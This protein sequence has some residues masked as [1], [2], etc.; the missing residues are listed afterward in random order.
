MSTIDAASETASGPPNFWPKQFLFCLFLTS[1]GPR[2][3]GA[4]S[5]VKTVMI[6]RFLFLLV[7][8]I[9]GG[10]ALA[11]DP[12]G[13]IRPDSAVQNAQLPEVPIGEGET[14]GVEPGAPATGAPAGQDSSVLT[15]RIERLER[16]LRQMTGE[17]E[18]LQH[19]VQVLEE[20]LRAAR[21]QEPVK[22]AEPAKTETPRPV[23]AAKPANPATVTPSAST[24]DPGQTTRDGKRADAFKPSSAPDAP[25]A[26]KPLGAATPSAP[27]ETTP[28]AAAS[29]A[30]PRES[31]APMDIAHG[32]LVGAQPATGATDTPLGAALTPSTA[33]SGGA[34]QE[35]DD[36]VA[37]LK[38]GRYEAAEQMLTT[39]LS[40]NPKSKLVPAA[41]Y[42]LG[43][44]YYQRGRRR[45]AAEKYLE[46]TSKYGQSSQAP[47]AL[48]RLG[49]SLSA[50]GAKEQA[51]AS[52]NEIGV[53]YPAA[54][55]RL[56]DVVE[57]ESKK[58]QC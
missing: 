50:L 36:A 17:N 24:S 27:L 25:G 51:C 18:E 33:P 48:L 12:L 9:P 46:I 32:R 5:A 34:Q 45:E 13:L 6:S 3:C 42:N 44:S 10:S 1:S 54:L 40:K 39:F 57:R 29:G 4:S 49:Q 14:I 22:T 16:Q 56:R 21:P 7:F 43:E 52:F 41:I 30:A 15:T 58:L 8:L 20:Q 2:P 47:D 37:A 11:F 19:K 23:E 35:F 28:K 31:G 53:K 55:T 26:P 38:G